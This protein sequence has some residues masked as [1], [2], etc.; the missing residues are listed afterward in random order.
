MIR[1]FLGRGVL[2]GWQR[3]AGGA[4][5]GTILRRCLVNINSFIDD[6]T[7]VE[8]LCTDDDS[9]M[10]GKGR[11]RTSTGRTDWALAVG[12]KIEQNI[13]KAQMC[14]HRNKHICHL[15]KLPYL[16]VMCV[17]KEQQLFVGEIVWQP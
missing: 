8:D 15:L 5:P 12:Y 3:S 17:R 2:L 14:R 6:F 7:V 11:K 13:T 1:G 10:A 4:A 9:S 16:T